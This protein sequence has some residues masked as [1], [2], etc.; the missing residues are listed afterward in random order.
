[1]KKTSVVIQTVISLLFHLST[2]L[3]H[4]FFGVIFFHSF[5]SFDSSALNTHLREV[6]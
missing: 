1:L 3:M 4:A 5:Q 6:E 2:E